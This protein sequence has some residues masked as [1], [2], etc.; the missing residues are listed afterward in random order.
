ML[1][2]DLTFSAQCKYIF[3]CSLGSRTASALKVARLPRAYGALRKTARLRRPESGEAAL[4]AV[5]ETAPRAEVGIGN[6]SEDQHWRVTQECRKVKAAV[7]KHS[8]GTK[9]RR[10]LLALRTQQVLV[11]RSQGHGETPA[12]GADAAGTLAPGP[13]GALTPARPNCLPVHRSTISQ[14]SVLEKTVVRD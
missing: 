9:Q 14:S 12:P 7:H 4:T 2:S 13:P 10:P 8:E 6:R 1:Y 3:P 5:L 11:T